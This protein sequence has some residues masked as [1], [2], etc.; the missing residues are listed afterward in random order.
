MKRNLLL[1]LFLFLLFGN[2]LFAQEANT[3]AIK[4]GNWSKSSTWSNGVPDDSKRAIIGKNRTVNIDGNTFASEVVVHGRLNVP[5]NGPIDKSLTTRWVHVNSGGVFKIGSAKNRFDLGTFTLTLNGVNPNAIHQIPMADNNMMT[6]SGNDGFLMVGG[7]GRLQFYGK[8]KLSFTKLSETAEANATSIIVENSIDRDHNGE[9]SATIDGSLNWEVGDEIVIASSSIEYT[10][11]DVRKITKIENLGSQTKLTLDE[12]LTY[13]H[14]GEIETY[15]QD[16]DPQSKKPNQPFSID[17]RAEVAL[18]SRNIKIQG[19][20]SQDTDS[21]FGDRALLQTSNKGKATNGIGGHVMIMPSAGRIVVDGVQLNLMGQAGRLGRYPFHWHI[22]RDRKG[23]VLKNSSITNSNNRGVVVH[24]TDNVLIEGVV[25]HDIHGHGFFTEDGVEVNNRFINNI[26]FG[27]HRVHENATRN[28]KAFVVDITDKFHDGGDR[29]RTTAAFWIANAGNEFSGNIVAGSEGSGYWFAQPNKPRGA[30]A[31]IVEYATYRP[32][33]IPLKKFKDNSVHSA[34][35]GFVTH[36]GRDKYISPKFFNNIDPVFEN[37]TIYQSSIGLYPLI[38]NIRHT[39]KNFKAADNN[40]TSWDSDPTLIDGGLF[41]GLSKGNPNTDVGRKVVG[42]MFYHGN[43]FFE[44]VHIAGFDRSIFFKAIKG[45]RVHQGCEV[46]GLTYENDGSLANM[47]SG[48]RTNFKNMRDIYDRDGSLTGIFGGGP[49]YTFIP[50]N[51]W[52]VDQSLGEIPGANEFRWVLSKQRFGDLQTEY[53]N[54]VNPEL[55]VPQIFI[56]SPHGIRE[57]YIEDGFYHRRAQLRLGAE[58]QLDFPNGFDFTK[59]KLLLTLH[60]WAMPSNSMGVVL[61]M[62]NMGNVLKPQV[63]TTATDLPKSNSLNELNNAN[64]D[65][66]FVV[67]NDLYV[68][69]MNRGMGISTNYINFVN[70]AGDQNLPA[71]VNFTTPDD[72]QKF[73]LGDNV[74]VKVDAFDNDGTIQQVQLFLNEFFVGEDNKAPFEWGN[75]PELKNLK[76]GTYVLKAL[77]TDND[78]LISEITR[79]I[80]VENSITNATIALN[81]ISN[82]NVQDLNHNAVV[83][84]PNPTNGKLAISNIKEKAAITIYNLL[85]SKIKELVI[86]KDETIDISN[87]PNGMYLLQVSNYLNGSFENKI[88]HKIIKHSN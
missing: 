68:K 30:A 7:N 25:L 77:A 63:L 54:I 60:Q 33:E 11:E 13:R 62:V 48:N 87:N 22:A 35:T 19:L 49:G 44:N 71:T 18:L 14:Y 1:Q 59:N 40:Q 23:D 79:N 21:K 57:E 26:A 46:E 4:N 52:A 2:N 8:D 82:K 27:I 31:D 65:S 58:Y 85:G 36:A 9:L 88:I 34:R 53:S 37:L 84:Y 20:S 38:R 81:N 76:Q 78:G 17:M 16:V 50:N 61:H 15:G 73:N 67:N 6:V 45:N 43:S 55:V 3:T 41:V 10:E 86:D 56:T 12:P 69:L 70:A 24:T 29:F 80:T 28:G 39:F 83:I 51:D 42:T 66:Y 74:E 32:Q 47:I 72:N 75:Q 5:K 64:T